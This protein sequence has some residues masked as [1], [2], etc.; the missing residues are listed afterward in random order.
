MCVLAQRVMREIHWR[1]PSD[2]YGEI[3]SAMQ[4]SNIISR[5]ES[6]AISRISTC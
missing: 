4:I 3:M 5:E 2:N 6:M 1:S